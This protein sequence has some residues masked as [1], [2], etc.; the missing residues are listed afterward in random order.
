MDLKIKQTRKLQGVVTVPGDKSISHRAIMLGALA[1]GTTEVTGFLMGQDCL[2]T[3]ECFRRLGVDIELDKTK[4]LINGKGLDGLRE[5]T[6]I[7]DVGNS[8][9]T[10]RLISGILAGQDFTT[11]LTGDQS[12]CRRPMGRITKPLREMGASILGRQEGNLAPLAIQGGNLKNIAYTT[13]VASAQVKSSILLAGLYS[14]GYTTVIEPVKSR[15]HTELMLKNF[16]AQVEETDRTVRIKGRPELVA[17]NIKVPGDISSAAFFIAAGA[18]V[19]EGSVIIKEVG[20]NPTR[21]GIIDVLQEMGARIEII[22]KWQTGGEII[23]DVKVE[24]S[25][26]KGVKIGGEIIPRLIDEIPILAVAAA[27]ASG[28]TEIRDAEE[29]KVKESNRLL[30][31][32]KELNKLGARVEELPDGLRIY[33]G[34]A[35]KGAVCDSSSDHRI[36]MSLAIAGLIAQGETTIQNSEVLNV[37]FPEFSKTL[38]KLTSKKSQV[39][40]CFSQ[41]LD[42]VFLW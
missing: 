19:P 5:P 12:I 9:T 8:G 16:G 36:A 34:K 7:L 29:L 23:G 30:A 28:I 6:D 25:N 35:L 3:V 26:L 37:S 22:N 41:E 17:Q 31:I 21:I 42:F 32:A 14:D 24:S 27:S 20:L 11:V 15:N 39:T 1:Q 18:V 33:G 2:S 13:P 4:V 10:I 40:S 38:Q